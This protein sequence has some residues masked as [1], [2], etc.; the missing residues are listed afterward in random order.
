MKERIRRL[1]AN[2]WVVAA[3][4][5]VVFMATAAPGGKRGG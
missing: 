1:A 3:T 5:L 2:R 4:L